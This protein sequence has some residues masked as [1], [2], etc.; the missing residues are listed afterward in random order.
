MATLEKI[1]RRAGIL[2]M[3]AIGLAMLG[4]ILGDFNLGSRNTKI[5][6]INGN[7]YEIQDY[8]NEQQTLLNF[9]K[10][11]YGDN[12]DPQIEQQVED[13]T[14]RRMVRTS[15]MGTSYNQLGL[16]VSIDEL[17]AMVAGTQAS[18]IGTS[19]TSAFSEPHPI[20]RQMFSNP[21][22]GEFNRY[23]MTN[24]FN[25][26]DREEYAQE[27]ERWKFIEDEIIDERLNQK[28]LTLIGKGLS[29]SNLDA[30]DYFTEN[31]KRV[32]FS[33]V[34]QSL[35]SVPDEDVTFSEADL[36]AYYKKHI[37]N[38]KS[39]E[40]R[41]IEYV[42]FEVAPSD[43]DDANAKLWSTQ[44]K[45]EFS[46]IED[47]E[48]LA[49]VNSVSDQPFDKRYYKISEV[50]E[51]LQDSLLNMGDDYIFGP[52]FEDDAYKLSRIHDTG[53]RPDSVRARHILIGY[54]I[55]GSIQRANEV[56][57]SLKV[58]LDAGG[59]FNALAMEY[60]ADESNRAIGGDLN[61]FQE[62][63]MET[64]FNDACFE[65]RTG[66]IVM[67][68]TRYGVHIIKIEAQSRRVEKV[69]IASIVHTLYPS[70]E[71][72]QDFYN[73][74]VKFRGKSTN[75]AK[76][77]EQAKEIGFDPRIV[78]DISKEQRAITG[79]GNAPQII[80][81]A[82]TSELGDISNIF[83][84]DDQFIVAALSEV[85][86]EGY[87]D[88]ETVRNE[89]ELAVRKKKKAEFIK[90]SMN[91]ALASTSNL[92]EFA[93]KQNLEVKEAEQV[94]FAN[95]YVSGIGLEPYIVG[96]ALSI[97]LE[98]MS[99][100]YIGENGVYVLRVNNREEADQ[101]AELDATAERLRLTIQ[102]RATYEAYNAMIK[103]AN[104]QDNRLKIFYGK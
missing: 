100:P 90:A 18:G 58:V 38:F 60:S 35:S 37:K 15:V 85:N 20:V 5:A 19:T 54:S 94:Q 36:K 9:Y 52:Y 95:T 50:S 7:T 74:A 39:E 67:A 34:T 22:T 73:R 92:E 101:V 6:E 12:L 45:N 65:N 99:G 21:E 49:Y 48:V 66:D 97:P 69:N 28:Y 30:E 87:S 8:Q 16:E 63:V 23:V 96:L 80:G 62:G 81:W 41:T 98:Q 40:A 70:N 78:P 2:V 82:Y 77:E 51:I 68:T 27:R 26:L 64:E 93:G 71:T 46:R 25:S 29:P 84:I 86:E 61:W 91:E 104:I 11:N 42:F 79:L 44:T 47:D 57:D 24:Y 102:S 59:N 13:E 103:S 33:Y 83:E 17:K 3:G 53:F 32:D 56:A 75:L 4:F 1:R 72:N 89:V 43:E 14:W 10:M 76:F 55:Y 88:F 31:G